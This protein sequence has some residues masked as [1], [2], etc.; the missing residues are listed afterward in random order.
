MK[1]ESQLMVPATM[2]AAGR[3]DCW[4][5]SPVR[6]NGMPPAVRIRAQNQSAPDRHAASAHL[7]MAGSCPLWESRLC[8]V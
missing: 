2:K 3:W 1:L 6:M 8:V 5:N 7:H 4:K